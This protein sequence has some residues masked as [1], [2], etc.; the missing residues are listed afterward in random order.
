[1]A[2]VMPATAE[3]RKRASV[4]E[5]LD[6]EWAA[7]HSGGRKSEYFLGEIREM[8]GAGWR[9]NAIVGNVILAI[10]TRLRGKSFAT[11]GSE[12]RVRVAV[13]GPFY[14]PDVSVSP[15]PPSIE[16]DRG[17]SL[18]N[19]VA[20]FEVLSPS[21]EAVD[22][23]EKLAN[24]MNIDSLSNYILVDA[25]VT[26]IDQNSRLADGSWRLDL[27]SGPAA[28]LRLEFLGI[29]IPLAEIYDRVLPAQD[30][31]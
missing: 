9:H 12:M 28:I 2:T 5:Y 20:V 16:C 24:Y 4:S 6:H 21:T 3:F 17:E 31:P 19:P 11:C 25:G 15:V 22:R 30:A 13:G 23:G 10:G 18:L 27:L 7:E 29:E 8:P 1:M 26:R 14:Y